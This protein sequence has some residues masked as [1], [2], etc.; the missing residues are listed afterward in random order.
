MPSTRAKRQV[1]SL[2]QKMWPFTPKSI[3][4][5][6][7]QT[8]K[9]FFPFLLM[10]GS[11]VVVPLDEPL[12]QSKTCH[13]KGRHR[14]PTNTFFST[15]RLITSFFS[16]YR[17]RDMGGGGSTGRHQ[18]K[19]LNEG[20]CNC[21]QSPHNTLGNLWWQGFMFPVPTITMTL[22]TMPSPL[23]PLHVIP[24]FRKKKLNILL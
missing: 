16:F 2:S 10:T 15:Q 13:S 18:N 17:V 22:F 14:V 6:S 11:C 21:R 4:P 24:T 12:N 23:P 20:Y 7:T 3:L 8:N 5:S 19:T 1:S 9:L